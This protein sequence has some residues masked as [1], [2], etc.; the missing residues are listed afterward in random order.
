MLKRFI[1]HILLRRHFWRHVDFDELSEIYVSMIF[2]GLSI[3]LTGLFVPL[4]MLR[5][6]YGATDVLLIPMFYFIARAL[7]FDVLSAYSVAKYGPKHTILLGNL[8]LIASTAL[9]LTLESI[10]WPLWLLGATWGASAS[11]F[12][13]PFHVDFS[14]IKHS[15]HGGKELGYVNVMEKLGFAIGPMIGGII[16]TVFGAQ[17]IFLFATALLIIGTVPLFTTSEPV[18]SN[19]RLDWRGLDITHHVR[20]FLSYTALAVENTI[21]VFVWPLYLGLFVLAGTTAYAKL[22]A[23]SAISVI[24]SVLA[25]LIIGKLIDRRKGRLLL[26]VSATV[27]ALLHLV[28]TQIVSYP[29]AVGLNI[30]NEAVTIGYRMPYHK[31]LYDAA[32]GLPGHR[33][34][35]IASLELFGSVLK[36]TMYG[37]LV[38]VSTITTDHLTTSIAFGIAA[39]ASLLVMT[40]R[41]R[42]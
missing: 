7:A 28:R 31:G 38:L 12:F 4:Y 19:Q 11:F 16:A 37:I 20:D 18:R 1:H 23:L 30:A 26:R 35:Y 5:L 24:A 21:C 29:T 27:N 14:K 9:F 2:R 36:A 33:I 22:G 34:V 32:D 6:G 15:D 8:M 41:F 42:L 39:I 25:A 13:I 40:E 3:S 10:S 17:Y